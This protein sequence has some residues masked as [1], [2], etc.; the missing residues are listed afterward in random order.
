MTFVLSIWL[1]CPPTEPEV[2]E[3][4]EAAILPQVR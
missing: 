1:A 3:P 2:P 4:A